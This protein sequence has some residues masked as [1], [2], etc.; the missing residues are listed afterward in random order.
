MPALTSTAGR[1]AA[2][3]QRAALEAERV[4]EQ[5]SARAHLAHRL[6]HAGLA[7]FADCVERPNTEPSIAV[8]CRLESCMADHEL[9]YT[10]LDDTGWTKNPAAWARHNA[11]GDFVPICHPTTQATC[12]LIVK[13]PH[14]KIDHWEA[15]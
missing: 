14:A 9:V 5:Q 7:V 10:M 4:I 3:R 1:H 6:R 13:V 2:D 8:N 12:L 15:A 11:Y